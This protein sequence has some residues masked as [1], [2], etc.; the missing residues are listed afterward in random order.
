MSS[1][2]SRI[3]NLTRREIEAR[4][5]GPLIRAFVDEFGRGKTFA[6]VNQV[7]EKLAKE[8]GALAAETA[9]GNSLA[10]YVKV[11]NAWFG[12]GEAIEQEILQQTETKLDYQITRCRY[13]EM[14]RELG[15]AD[16]GFI[17]SCARDFGLVKGFNPKMKLT[18]PTT[19]ME[20]SD[21][22]IFYFTLE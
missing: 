18:R 13:A 19:I 17:L 1:N 22:C 10:D 2:L 7:I 11:T 9:G 8:S 6:V 4:I 5:A 16:L 12:V 21:R 15:M 3:D 14:Y 20:G